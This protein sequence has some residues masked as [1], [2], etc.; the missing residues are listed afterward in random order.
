MYFSWRGDISEPKVNRTCS[1]FNK[2]AHRIAMGFS[3]NIV[4]GLEFPKI[5]LEFKELIFD[6]F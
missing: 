6:S 5:V 2:K 1:I 4:S 3:S